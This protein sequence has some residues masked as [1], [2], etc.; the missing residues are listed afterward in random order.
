MAIHSLTEMDEFKLQELVS[1]KPELSDKYL[2]LILSFRVVATSTE[3]L[4][5][6][7]ILGK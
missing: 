5:L 4:R 6:Q 2:Q 1:N 7:L 3:E